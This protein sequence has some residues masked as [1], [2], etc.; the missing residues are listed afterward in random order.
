MK[1]ILLSLVLVFLILGISSYFIW[2]LGDSGSSITSAVTVTEEKVENKVLEN[3]TAQI[4]DVPGE[5]KEI[6]EVLK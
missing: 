6:E 3:V 2:D 5:V 4:E 1:R